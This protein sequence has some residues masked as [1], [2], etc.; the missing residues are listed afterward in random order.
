[1]PPVVAEDGQRAPEAKAW[2]DA[3][4]KGDTEWE[5]QGGSGRSCPAEEAADPGGIRRRGEVRAGTGGTTGVRPI[6]G[7]TDGTEAT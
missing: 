3:K 1:M 7:N 2:Y 5:K 4:A 6:R